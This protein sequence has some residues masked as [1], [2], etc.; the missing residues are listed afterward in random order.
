[1]AR[2]MSAAGRPTLWEQ[3]GETRTVFSLVFLYCALHLL[4]RVLLSPNFNRSEAA[5]V[6]F[7][8]SLQWGYRAGHPPLAAWLS[9]A[10]MAASGPSR[11]ALFVLREFII[12]VGL[13][14]YFVAARRMIGD[15][16][17]AALSVMF[18][19]AAYGIGWL[20]HFGSIETALLMAM[21]AFY[22]WADSRALL[23]ATYLD[24]ALLGVVTGVGVLTSYL[25]LVLPFA[26][27][28][29]LVFVPDL[30]ARLRIQPLLIA[31][32]VALAIVA[33]YFAFTPDAFTTTANGARLIALRDLAIVLVVFAL[34]AALLFLIL[35]PRTARPL[36]KTE[37]TQ[38]WLRFLRI[39]IAA[40]AVTCA[41][42]LLL[43]GENAFAFAYLVLL[44]LPIVLFLR[45]KLVYGDNI[46]TN[47]KRFALAVLACI[48][49][50]V[51]V[52]VG[53]YETRAHD[54]QNCAEYWPMPRYATAFRQ[55]GFLQGTIAAPDAALAGNLRVSFADDR[56]VTPQAPAARFG[57][58][59]P[60]EC[61]IVWEGEGALPKTLHDYVA[62]TYG[63]KLEQR[64]MQ[65]DVEATLL[66][67]K[68]RRV[69]MN[70]LILAQGACDRPRG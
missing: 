37:Q 60:G 15:A 55:A 50:G 62:Q 23:R 1:M 20:L 14:A 43:A 35:C 4:L 67:S 46:E 49:I 21:C 29:A 30:R 19:M 7:A 16:H 34:P 8:Q 32:I 64:A 52:R 69:R 48:V 53:M 56:V 36:P 3:L 27:S 18:L 63:A 22:L 31:A 44:P 65:G 38:T 61:L 28:V 70:F 51:A 66:T 41:A 6:L 24:Y 25:F 42:V 47:D 12:G 40:A 45:A 11:L 57:P 26:M 33:P 68:D 5:D 9:W 10:V 13:M 58:P 17:S 2:G 59:V 39:S 54:C